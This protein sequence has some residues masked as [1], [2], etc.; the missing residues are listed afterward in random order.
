MINI[1]GTLLFLLPAAFMLLLVACGAENT[2]KDMDAVI[3]A[4]DKHNVINCSEF[5]FL[6]ESGATDGKRCDVTSSGNANT[7]VEFTF[8]EENNAK[9]ACIPTP[10]LTICSEGH[11][12][13]WD[14]RFYGNIHL[15]V[16]DEDNG[17]SVDSLI[18][19]LK[20]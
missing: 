1:K 15:V 14:L 11:F 2:F 16:Y 8:W 6:E 13:S 7:M 3:K 20:D 12:E 10:F 19:D 17:V 9:N 4:L 18:S 5:G